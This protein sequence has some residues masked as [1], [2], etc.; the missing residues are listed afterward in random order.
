MRMPLLDGSARELIDS[1]NR[2]PKGPFFNKIAQE[3][4]RVRRLL[5]DPL[6]PQFEDAILNGLMGLGMGIAIKGGRTA[7][8]PRLRSCLDAARRSGALD[9][10]SDCCLSSIDLKSTRKAIT[11][12]YDCLALAGTLHP[13][14]QS[15]VGA[16]KTLIGFFQSCF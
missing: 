10:F 15:H 4:Y 6:S 2:A 12:A 5:G 1:Y 9:Q 7:L 16:T 14:D 13:T 11:T 3:V 8:Y